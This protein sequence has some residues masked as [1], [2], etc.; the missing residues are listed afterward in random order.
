MLRMSSNVEQR[1]STGFE[2]QRKESR[3]FCHI[4]G[5]SV[6]GTLKTRW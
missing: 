5:T 2:Q 3:L 4:S 1:G 6:C